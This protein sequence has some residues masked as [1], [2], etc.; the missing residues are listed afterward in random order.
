MVATTGLFNAGASDAMRAQKEHQAR[1]ANATAQ[2]ATG[3]AANTASFKPASQSMAA[4][5][6]SMTQVIEQAK[7]NASN[8]KSVIQLGARTLQN[9][10]NTLA[11]MDAL[12][13]QASAGELTNSDRAQIH[14]VFDKLR[15]GLNTAALQT[16]FNGKKLFNGGAGS[17]S[18]NA[19]AVS[20]AGSVVAVTDAFA[21]GIAAASAGNITG[22]ASEAT[23]VGRTATAFDYSVKVGNQTFE[24]LN[25]TPANGGT[26]TLI[27]KQNPA[28]QIVL[29]FAAAV[30][31]T[32]TLAEAKVAF[33]QAMGLNPGQANA[34]FSSA[35]TVAG[36][37]IADAG[38][39]TGTALA[40]EYYVTVAEDAAGASWSI[41]DSAGKILD[42]VV[43]SAGA[44]SKTVNFANAGITLTTPAGYDPAV[45]SGPLALTVEQGN[46]VTITSQTGAYAANTTTVSFAGATT[47]LLGTASVKLNAVGLTSTAEAAVA[48]D[49]IKAAMAQ[50]STMYG[51][52]G[53]AM[54]NLELQEKVL[55]DT[56]SELQSAISGIRDADIPAA[57][58]QQKIAEVM[59]ELANIAQGKA[60]QQ[61]QQLLKLAQQA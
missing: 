13:A 26:M 5:M 39:V 22:V 15:E 54:G 27:S 50:I 35:S 45:A 24:A 48:S 6:D 23:V 56:V 42:T 44:G 18:I 31:A 49:V 41:Q 33:K 37:Q 60:L 52:L 21:A 40:G 3:R 53:A 32:D 59:A 57:I 30:T 38:T 46:A 17:V 19:A 12:A 9:M 28:N 51:N 55:G 11:T 20:E 8:L 4:A 16:E 61:S 14:A 47:D 7:L 58:T 25:V 34:T 36:A 29:T 2:L 43:T 10:R 1:G